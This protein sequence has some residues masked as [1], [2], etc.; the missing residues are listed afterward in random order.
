VTP[1]LGEPPE[2]DRASRGDDLCES[3][4]RAVRPLVA[5]LSAALN[6]YVMPSAE[7]AAFDFTP[8]H[9]GILNGALPGLDR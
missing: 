1:C 5:A 7:G 3:T 8:A 6:P 2:R 9:R 4:I